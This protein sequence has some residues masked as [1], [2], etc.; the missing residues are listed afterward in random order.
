ME[1]MKAI[2]CS[3][4]VFLMFMTKTKG[5]RVGLANLKPY[6]AKMNIHKYKHTNK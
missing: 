5:R 2:P 4:V 1:N 6:G 3:T